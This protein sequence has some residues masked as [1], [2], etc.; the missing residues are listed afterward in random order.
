MHYFRKRK[1][2]RSGGEKNKKIDK[3]FCKKEMSSRNREVK[4]QNGEDYFRKTQKI[5][6]MERFTFPHEVLSI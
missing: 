5:T 1:Y 4:K 2:N 6:R 3:K